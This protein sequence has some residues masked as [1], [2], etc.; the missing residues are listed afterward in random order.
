MFWIIEPHADDAFLS[1]HAHLTT[2]WSAH[3]RTIVTL[4]TDEERAEETAAYARAIGCRHMTLGLPDGRWG[5][6]AM[7]PP[8]DDWLPQGHGDVLICPLGLRH[9]DHIEIGRAHV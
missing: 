6:P 8:L 3:A 5:K 7:I 4:F 2:L 9:P 1:L